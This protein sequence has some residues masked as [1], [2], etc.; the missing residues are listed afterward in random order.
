MNDLLYFGKIVLIAGAIIGIV[1]AAI[2]VGEWKGKLDSDRTDF[3]KFIEEVRKD[4]KE[5][6]LRL[7]PAVTDKSSPLKLTDLGRSISDRLKA[8]EWAKETAPSI[9]DEVTGKHPYEIQNFCLDYVTTD[10]QLTPSMDQQ[11]KSCAYENGIT[12]RQVLEVL[13]IELRDEL[14]GALWK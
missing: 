2:R 11:I 12:K 5:I 1:A 7:S 3:K 8:S 6:L 14:I 4:I 13:A 10:I 9:I